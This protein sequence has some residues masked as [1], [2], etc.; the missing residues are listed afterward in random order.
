[1]F[2]RQSHSWAELFSPAPPV[3]VAA[4][5]KRELVASFQGSP[6][7]VG[8]PVRR[9]LR[10]NCTVALRRWVR[11]VSF[12]N[13]VNSAHEFVLGGS[14]SFDISAGAPLEMLNTGANM[15]LFGNSLFI[16]RTARKKPVTGAILSSEISR[17]F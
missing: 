1:M 6:E 17:P 8:I 2:S 16:H 11:D 13:S 15:N 12:L 9:A 3:T 4:T 10:Q 5:P 14:E 7:L